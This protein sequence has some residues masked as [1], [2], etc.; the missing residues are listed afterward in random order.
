MPVDN[1]LGFE[2]CAVADCVRIEHDDVGPQPCFQHAAIGET[3][4]L[5]RQRGEFA[6]GVF[7]WQLVLFAHVF[8]QDARKGAVR[9]RMRMLPAEYAVRRRSLGIVI[10]RNPRL[11]ERQCDVGLGHAEDRYHRERLVLDEQVEDGVERVGAASG[12]NRGQV[13]PC[14]GRS[15]GFCT[16]LIRIASGPG[17]SCHSLSQDVLG[18]SMSLRMRARVAGSLRRSMSLASPP[19]C[20]HG[21]MK[22]E[23]S[24]EPRRVGV[25]VGGDV[26]ARRARL[27]DLGDD[28][29][30][31]S[32]VGFAGGLQVPDLDREMGFAAD[33]DASSIAVRI[34]SPS[35][36]MCVA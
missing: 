7:E 31:A 8:S 6:D 23:K 21:G 5:R 20:A 17:I 24:V 15:F 30:H 18:V 19:S 34:A 36:R 26:D 9:P 1:W 12:S 32:P 13:L 4:A 33:A 29:R 25:G 27:F 3:H 35:L 28:L 11:L 2:S 14:S 16:T 22:A 10:N